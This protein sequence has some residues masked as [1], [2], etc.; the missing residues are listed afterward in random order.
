RCSWR[1]HLHIEREARSG[2]ALRSSRS[3]ERKA[4]LEGSR[5]GWCGASENAVAEE[6]ARRGAEIHSH[7]LAVANEDQAVL[8]AE[9]EPKGRSRGK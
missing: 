5:P 8:K 9:I 7:L 2:R 6:V 3:I 1:A 4:V